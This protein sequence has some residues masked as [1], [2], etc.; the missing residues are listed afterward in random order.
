MDQ[1]HL[2]SP[3]APGLVAAILSTLCPTPGAGDTVRTA[4]AQHASSLLRQR[5]AFLYPPSSAPLPAT[6]LVWLPHPLLTDAYLRHVV[7]ARWTLGNAD[8]L[9]KDTHVVVRDAET[10][11][12][13]VG[14]DLRPDPADPVAGMVRVVMVLVWEEMEWR[15][16]DFRVMGEVEWK[17][18]EAESRPSRI[19]TSTTTTAPPQPAAA[20]SDNDKDDD[21]DDGYWAAYDDR[22][23]GPAATN[24]APARNANADPEDAY[25]AMYDTDTLPPLPASAHPAPTASG[26]SKAAVLRHVQDSA[27]SL[28][29]L[30]RAAGCS[31]EE[32]LLVLAAGLD[33]NDHE[34]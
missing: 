30:A 9:A 25:W 11:E 22:L 14:V 1:Q 19:T 12:A 32:V 5:I 23:G 31:R 18:V 21:S 2:P 13:L 20:L 3:P 16:H 15:V 28:W 17:R 10:V 34:E 7:A 4:A 29:A 27:K 33:V 8:A 26:A 24:P 6:A